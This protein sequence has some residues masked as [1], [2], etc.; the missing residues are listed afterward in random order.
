MNIFLNLAL[1][2]WWIVAIALLCASTNEMRFHSWEDRAKFIAAV[3]L[4]WIVF[5]A[6]WAFRRF[7]VKGAN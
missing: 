4:W 7:G 3:S 2:V 5:P 6:V 1:H